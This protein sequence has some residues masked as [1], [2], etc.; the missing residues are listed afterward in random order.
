MIYRLRRRFLLVATVSVLAVFLLILGVLAISNRITLNRSADAL[1]DAIS[2]GGGRFPD[3]FDGQRPT[4]DRRPA[5]GLITEESRFSTRYFTV[6]YA[7]D[8]SLLGVNTDAIHAVNATAAITAADSVRDGRER[9]WYGHYRYKIY[10]VAEGTAITFVDASSA[11][12]QG[13]RF[14]LSALA[15]LGTSSA[16]ILLLILLLSR[17]AILP[18][19]ESYRRQKQFIT[20]ASHELKTP[21]TLILTDTD[22]AEEELG[23]SEWLDDIRGEG[24]HM[25]TLIGQM[26]TLCRMDEETPTLSPARFSLSEAVLDTVSEFS[27]L[28]DTRGKRLEACVSPDLAITADEGAIRRLLAILLDNA[29]KYCDDG[30]IIHVALAA[31]RHSAVLTVENDFAAVDETELT[32]LFDRF[33]R[34]DRARTA[35]GGFGLGLSIAQATVTAHRG[36]LTAYRP[37]AGRI[38][39][40]VVLRQTP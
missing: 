7:P 11:R 10:T 4:G 31:G 32:R 28:A 25:A 17:R 38:G 26:V 37:A 3:L 39:F 33:Y 14:L 6:W 23:R 18:M 13:E 29:V 30:G 22:I 21:L 19:A 12:A 24:S 40:R 36:E 20:D 34:A 16:V 8:G 15:V 27:A 35:G 9:G 1:T 5:P 2:M